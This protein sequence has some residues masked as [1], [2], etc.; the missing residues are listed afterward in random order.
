MIRKTCDF[1]A[2]PTDA[3]EVLV[4]AYERICEC[5]ASTKLDDARE[6]FFEGDIRE[7]REILKVISEQTCIH[8]YTVDMVF[9]LSCVERAKEIFEEKGISEEVF[10]DTMRD[11][12]AKL[13]EC[14]SV[15][16]IWG[17]FVVWWYPEF[18]RAERF[19]LG[20]LQFEKKEFPFENYKDIVKK[21][22]TV[23]NF[24]IPSGAPLNYESIVDS[25]KRA[26]KFF[27]VKGIMPIFL[28][29]WLIYP[30]HGALF[31]EGSNLKRFYELFDILDSKEHSSNAELWRIF[32][33]PFSSDM[34]LETL[35]EDTSL[36]RSFKQF[37]AQGGV[38]GSGKG[39][40]LFDGE[41]M[42]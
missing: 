23:Y 17:T 20:R 28:S 41:R 24:H 5:G 35:P 26:Y 3:R 15:Y 10:R 32:S 1:L 12:N 8:R 16:G 18:F 29:S 13:E 39:I 11:L 38:M 21:G 22:D 14:K 33:V 42:I 36:Q 2:F 25:F 37:F 7:Y 34:D 27:D 9:L 40:I 31:R 6:L 19:A 4:V 30:P